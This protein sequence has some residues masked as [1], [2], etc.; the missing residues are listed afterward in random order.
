MRPIKFRAWNPSHQTMVYFPGPL[1]DLDTPHLM[2]C[3]GLRDR[4]GTEIYEGDVVRFTE[5]VG[6]TTRDVER[7]V[8]WDQSAC[9]F[10]TAQ[11]DDEDGEYL[12]EDSR[13]VVLGN[14]YEHGYLLNAQP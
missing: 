3:T 1:V 9:R 8:V 13:M 12:H 14:I 6:D 7:L 11:E 10:S 5:V 4:H 2:Q